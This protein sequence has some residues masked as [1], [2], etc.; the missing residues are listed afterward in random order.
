MIESRAILEII[1]SIFVLNANQAMDSVELKINEMPNRIKKLSSKKEVTIL[2]RVIKF[3]KTI[4]IIDKINSTHIFEENRRPINFDEAA[5]KSLSG[6]EIM[7]LKKIK[8]A[9]SETIIAAII[10]I[11]K[12]IIPR[13]A[14]PTVCGKNKIPAPNAVEKN[15]TGQYKFEI[16]IVL[17]SCNC[18]VRRHSNYLI[19]TL[20]QNKI[21]RK[22][23]VK[24]LM[25]NPHI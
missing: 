19:K 24:M 6:C 16:F 13:T 12:D 14:G 25:K 15:V 2:T 5:K 4:I 11:R 3:I 20:I 9:I 1:F 8:C 17:L 7:N 23:Q 18:Y 21:Y 10:K 22:K